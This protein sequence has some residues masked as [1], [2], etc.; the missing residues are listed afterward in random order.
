V[1]RSLTTALLAILFVGSAAAC[2]GAGPEA[3]TPPATERS[4]RAPRPTQDEPEAPAALT[5]EAALT[6]PLDEL[7]R[8]V[9][10]LTAG[11]PR[12]PNDEAEL[13]GLRAVAG[14]ARI[15]AL[16]TSDDAGLELARDLLRRASEAEV[17]GEA[18]CRAAADRVRLE[19]RDAG[20]LRLASELARAA[21]RR[22]QGST[23]AAACVAGL[24]DAAHAL[25]AFPPAPDQI[26]GRATLRRIAL[27][28]ADA[29]TP[30]GVRLVLEFDRPVEPGSVERPVEGGRRRLR[31]DFQGAEVAVEQGARATRA[32]QA[33]GGAVDVGVAGLVAY[34]HLQL[35]GAIAR[36]ELELE[37]DAVVRRFVLGAEAAPDASYRLV[38]EVR[39]EA[40]PSP[41]P[42][43]R[44]VR[45]IVLDPGHG[46]DEWGAS[47]G[48]VRESHLTFDLA[49]R[50]AAVLH[51][52]LPGIEVL[53]TR[54]DDVVVP[55]EARTAMANDAAADLFVSI[56]L[57]DSDVAIDHGGVTTFVLD[58]SDDAHALRLAARENGTTA[59]ELTGMTRLLAELHREGQLEAS[60][61]LADR[62]QRALLARGRTILPGLAD[63][64]VRSALFYV[65]V[66]VR[67]PAVL[68]EA[69]FLTDPDELRALRTSRYRQ[70]LA[71]GIAEGIVHYVLGE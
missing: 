66:G 35:P 24:A 20:D 7:R 55:L 23:A 70:A 11:A 21:I 5:E 69:S 71:E 6:A 1:V 26:G 41:R 45:T 2:D 8:R 30:A 32:A 47:N 17:V 39:R 16:R 64:G 40:A 61:R 60:R 67:M 4:A 63:R 3:A 58:T 36:V 31:L 51:D 53:L 43:G 14:M 15:L 44:V 54:T 59:A 50:T 38:L 42:A 25:A 13:E 18:P 46:G 22:F 34:R 57:N 52:R 56:H 12:A 33:S 68:V 65:L 37:P 10:A 49:R 27:Y 62:V 19:A 29:P 9:Q 48:G 28:G